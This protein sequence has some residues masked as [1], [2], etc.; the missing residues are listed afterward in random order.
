MGDHAQ[1]WQNR[2]RVA[3]F[4]PF[5][6]V[7]WPGTIAAVVFLQGC[8]WRCT[9][10]HNPEL[11]ERSVPPSIHWSAVEAKLAKR[12][13][14]LDGVVFSGGE[15]TVDRAL[16]EAIARVKEMGFRVGLHTGGAYPDRL[17][18][19]L[20]MLDWVGLDLK[21]SPEEYAALT[22]APGSGNNAYHSA[23][24]VARSGVPYECRLT[25]HPQ[26]VSDDT[27]RLL[28]RCA[29]TLGCERFVIQEFRPT[30]NPDAAGLTTH[31]SMPAAL[32]EELRGI[33]PGIELRTSS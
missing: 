15:P 19:L 30:P 8:P 7:D 1:P 10:C 3:G 13:G 4:Q 17:A 23:T 24:L 27:A 28:V 11:Q 21:T 33:L 22:G 29:K 18:R 20:G 12:I 31:V 32:L 25:Y 14:W 2:L 6:T 16:P 26:V 9:Y 5:S